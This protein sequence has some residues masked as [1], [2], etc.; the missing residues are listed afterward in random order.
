MSGRWSSSARLIG[1]AAVLAVLVRSLGTDPF[2]HGVRTVDG[3]SLA[4]AAG[5]AAVTTVC[6]AWRWSL[7]A[8][9]LGVAVPLRPAIAAYYRSQFL[10]T[11]LP[12]GVLGD[13]H[14]GVVHGRNAGNVGRGLRAVGWE[15]AAGQVVQAA[16]AA[17]VLLA[18]PSPVHSVMPT[19]VIGLTALMILATLMILPTAVRPRARLAGPSRWA[20]ATRAAGA[21]LRDGLLARRAW[22]GIVAAS[23][24]V[25]AGHV[26]T[27]LVA[28]RAT[29]VTA[30]PV[31]LVPLALLILLAMGI[32]ANIGG[33]GPR[34]GVAAWAFG[35]AGLGAAQGLATAVG[36]GVLVMA[37][38]LP[39]ALVLLADLPARRA[40]DGRNH[41]DRAGQQGEAGR[42]DGARHE[43]AVLASRE[44][45]AHA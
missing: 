2:L 21:D 13:V 24:V 35:A 31:R 17:V 8:R 38:N 18:V 20:R 22:P 34:E 42:Q 40:G 41:P 23:T 43:P 32:P 29:G 39:G 25:V 7:V 9:G 28:A 27:F 6:C 44:G 19:V 1:G 11:T 45:A 37:A 5:L 3:W 12:G 4:A 30:S 26:A 15:R 14:R 10:N 33:W 16:L 36:Y